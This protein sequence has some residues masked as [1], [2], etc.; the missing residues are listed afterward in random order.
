MRVDTTILGAGA[1]GVMAAIQCGLRGRSVL[2]LDHADRCGRKIRVSGGGK[3]NFT[4]AYASAADYV[5]GN[6]HFV[7]SA[8]A[9]FTPQDFTAFMRRRRL[10]IV[11]MGKGM[12]FG[13]NANRVADALNEEA[14]GTGARF[15]FNAAVRGARRE[16]DGF[17]VNV[18][19]SEIPDGKVLCSSLVV[20]TGG[21]AWPQVGASGLS[22]EIARGFGLRVTELRPGLAPLLASVESREWC[23]A[24]SGISLPCRIVLPQTPEAPLIEGDLLF[25]HKGLSGP[26]ALDASL[27]WRE[28]RPLQIDFLPDSDLMGVLTSTPRLEL[29]NALSRLLPKRLALA[30]CALEGWSGQ[31]AGLSKKRL[32]AVESAVR[33]FPFAAA[34]VDDYAKAEVTLGGVDTAQFSSKTMECSTIPGLYFTG[35]ALDVAGRLGGY[36]LQWAWASGVAA[37][38]FA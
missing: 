9:R 17:V 14:V 25:T 33:A 5:C 7:K 29:K 22:Y 30:L 28:G 20:A 10:T 4:N 3:C 31:V 2:V 16:G 6:P 27:Y 36:N 38:S 13:D 32:L 15:V 12:L 1:S 35:E 24:L 23:A 19:A 37:G 18:S 11:D 21:L 26:A 34:S 8:L